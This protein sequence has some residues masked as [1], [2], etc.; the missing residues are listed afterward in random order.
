MSN[1]VLL[2][3]S[4]V[5]PWLT[6]FF[7][8]REAIKRYMPVALFGALVTTITGE[9]GLALNWWSIDDT[10]FPFYHIIPYTYGAFPVG[11]IW[12]FTFTYKRFWLFMLTNAALD[13]VLTF[14]MQS[15][16]TQRG[17]AELVNMNNTQTFLIAIINAV[18]LYGYQI[19]QEEVLVV[20]E[21]AT[22]SASLQ[23]AMAKPLPGEDERPKD[24]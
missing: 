5:I 16:T 3:S 8:K 21:Q 12:I 17:I 20:H 14:P 2:W 4:I 15:F 19:W 1:Q 13:F 6:L 18:V 23:P 22:S 10:I 11:I 7:L 24:N 9:L